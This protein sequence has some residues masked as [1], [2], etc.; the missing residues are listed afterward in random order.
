LV[1]V[2]HRH[3]AR[4]RVRLV[5]PLTH[6]VGLSASPPTAQVTWIWAQDCNVAPPGWQLVCG[7]PVPVTR[8]V[9]AGCQASGG[10]R[11]A[12][13]PRGRT[14]VRSGGAASWAVGRR[15]TTGAGRCGQVLS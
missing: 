1:A 8:G 13:H 14:G 3:P 2:P 7:A 10:P 9:G 5:C 6:A 11:S 4:R 15:P 12:R